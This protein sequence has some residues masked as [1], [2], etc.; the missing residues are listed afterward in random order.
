MTE[1]DLKEPVVRPPHRPP[2]P[3]P[4]LLRSGAS[5]VRPPFL[6]LSWLALLAALTS[7]CL[8]RGRRGEAPVTGELHVEGAKAVDEA[9]LVGKLA[10]T[11]SGRWLFGVTEPHPFDRELLATD[12]RRLERVYRLLGFYEAKVV[13][14]RLSEH[15]GRM[16]VT[17]VV[18]EGRPT[19]VTR[20]D[21]L[22]LEELDPKSRA[23]VVEDPPLREGDVLT[24][25]AYDTL[26][27][28][29]RERLRERGWW[30]ATVEGHVEVAPETA[31]ASVSVTVVT[32][33]RLRI[34]RLFVAG[35]QAVSRD[36][37]VLASGLK[38]GDLV[39]PESLQNAQRHIQ[40]LGIFTLVQVE[41][42]APEAP[43]RVPV[44]I[45]VHEA[46]F[47][48][49]ELGLGVVTDPYR[50]VGQ[51]RGQWLHKNLARGLQQL[52]LGA[53]LGYAVLPGLPQWLF[54]EGLTD[55]GI[56]G[57][58]RVE[59]V[60][61][62]LY[63]SP[64]DLSAMTDYTKD[65]TNAFAY[66]RLGA[67]VGLPIHLDAFL[68][69]LVLTPAV[70][71]DWYFGV[72][73]SGEIPVGSTSSFATSGCG[74]QTG[75]AQSDRCVIGYVE[76]RASV[77]HR[78][79]PVSAH[80]GWY[81]NATAQLAGLPGSEFRYVRLFPE[82][83]GYLPLSP[84]TTL[85]ARVRWGM[86][87]K[88]DAGGRDLPGVAKF[89][90]GGANSVR[91][92]GAQ[93]LGPRDFLV[94]DNPDFDP[95]TDVDCASGAAPCKNRN[96][97]GAPLPLGGNR[98]LEG[99]LE[100]RLPTKWESVGLVLFTDAGAVSNAPATSTEPWPSTDTLRAGVGVGLRLRTPVGPVRLDL[101]QRVQ[102]WVQRPGNVRLAPG[103]TAPTST[104]PTTYAIATSCSGTGY[105]TKSSS[106]TF[107]QCYAEGG[108]LTGVQLFL[109]I[110]EAF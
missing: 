32:G 47:I 22:G 10:L 67:R 102:S 34:G 57:D 66:Q 98:L 89:F 2:R 59:Y 109:T 40:A 107:H 82:L 18:S 54:G 83:R 51:M 94:Q 64:V 39:T 3:P 101:A 48:S 1:D 86:L 6:R 50:W 36:R 74:V 108:Y 30:N 55:Q 96:T 73:Q 78:D 33:D 90:A 105:G 23:A 19:R 99:S 60:Q 93:Q 95:T 75:A 42:A 72:R 9:D 87:F 63:R 38:P 97:A 58:G 11:E 65:I 43:G 76:G 16:D 13:D 7:S 15:R 37:V 17:F 45:T 25:E 85:A 79:S 68:E 103:T 41:P 53:G 8:F 21:W 5:M 70:A 26:K 106:P 4:P 84:R 24:E 35:A 56:V 28:R 20:L 29:L 52:T 49:R 61:P 92:T 80:R 46:P 14:T 91:V 77:D 12:A 44:V 88:R 62:R 71:Y 69:G 110:G 31:S 100:L 27:A 81:A 104:D